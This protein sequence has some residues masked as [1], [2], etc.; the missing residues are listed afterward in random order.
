MTYL[1]I[2]LLIEKKVHETISIMKCEDTN[3][4][5]YREQVKDTTDSEGKKSNI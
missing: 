5:K 4:G 1:K 3:F 2:N